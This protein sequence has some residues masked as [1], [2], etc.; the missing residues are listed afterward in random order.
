MWLRC[1][2]SRIEFA[3]SAN[4][5][6]SDNVKVCVYGCREVVW[7]VDVDGCDGCA[8]V[9]AICAYDGCGD[10]IDWNLGSLTSGDCVGVDSGE[11][12]GVHDP[13]ATCA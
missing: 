8:G 1:R 4:V 5:G 7:C 13:E 12:V 2:F 11:C 10:G 9:E 3:S 6:L